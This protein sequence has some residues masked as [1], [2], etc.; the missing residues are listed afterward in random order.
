[1]RWQLSRRDYVAG[2][3]GPDFSKLSQH[4]VGDRA[5]S[6]DLDRVVCNLN[7]RR[8]DSVLRRTAINNQRNTAAQ[9]I[10]DVLRGCWADTP[11][12]ICARCRQRPFQFPDYFPENRMR[13]HPH[14]HRV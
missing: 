14:R 5:A 13:A 3:S 6:Q 9:L 1:M 4:V 10:E 12:P 2:W 7:N 11:E 8:F